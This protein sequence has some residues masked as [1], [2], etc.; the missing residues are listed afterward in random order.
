MVPAETIE[1]PV[2][3]AAEERMPLVRREPENRPFAVPAVA[4]ADP[5]AGQVRHLDAVAVAEAQG[6]FD[7]VRS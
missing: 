2:S 3:D 5:A 6:A 7:P 1:F 4:D